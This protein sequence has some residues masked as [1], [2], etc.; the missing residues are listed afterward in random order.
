VTRDFRFTPTPREAS[1]AAEILA[2]RAG[3]P[4]W[5]WKDPR[6]CLF[7]DFWKA[8]VPQ[9]Q[10]LC[11]YR[12]PLDV[13]LSLARRGEVVGFDFFNALDGMVRLQCAPLGPRAASALGDAGM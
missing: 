1:R 7:L 12:N 6:T 9:A 3:R 11:V 8:R 10:Y 4:L 2:A 5:G 13:I